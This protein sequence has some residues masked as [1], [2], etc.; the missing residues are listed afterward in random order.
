MNLLIAMRDLLLR[1]AVAA[2]L[3]ISIVTI[4]SRTAGDEIASRSSRPAGKLDLL[5]QV[6]A[7]AVRTPEQ[8]LSELRI[9]GPGAVPAFIDSVIINKSQ[10]DQI[11]IDPKNKKLIITILEKLPKCA[12]DTIRA[13]DANVDD[14]QSIA[15]IAFAVLESIGASTEHLV[16]SVQ[17]LGWQEAKIPKDASVIM[18]FEGAASAILRKNRLH[19]SYIR[20]C[21]EKA[22]PAV[23]LGLIGALGQTGSREGTQLLCDRLGRAAEFDRFI[24]QQIGKRTGPL[25]VMAEDRNFDMIRRYLDSND[26]LVARE[27]ALAAGR[28]EAAGCTEAL[29]KLLDSE[30]MSIRENAYWAVLQITGLRFRLDK[31]KWTR[32]F[33]DEQLWWHTRGEAFITKLSAA[34]RTE[35]AAII[36]ELAGHRLFRKELTNAL[37]QH[38]ELETDPETLR[39]VFAAINTLAAPAAVPALI[40]KIDSEDPTMRS[41]VLASLAVITGENLGEE[42][43][44]WE[45]RFQ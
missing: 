25:P 38:L 36:N 9:A 11:P 21:L 7:G 37:V 10:S 23:Q 6:R 19:Y 39:L 4:D 26:P 13:S 8:L 31:R 34:D 14:Y 45:L 1:P 3:A 33:E 32:W 30:N 35:K 22:S 43:A 44:A 24:L 27:A 17:I 42:R 15:L 41:S 20:E 28:L 2:A 16:S 40:A 12:L 5:A 29:I 18:A